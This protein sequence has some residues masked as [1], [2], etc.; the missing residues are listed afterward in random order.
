MFDST[1]DGRLKFVRDLLE[2]NA[3][4]VVRVNVLQRR[5]MKA[6]EG[7]GAEMM[8]SASKKDKKEKPKETVLKFELPKEGDD[9]EE[10]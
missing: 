7:W 2:T 4:N 1:R 9:F 10:F 5:K 6:N 8:E 3:R